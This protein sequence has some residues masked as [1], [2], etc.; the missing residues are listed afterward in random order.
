MGSPGTMRGPQG[1]TFASFPIPEYEGVYGYP[2]RWTRR[3][4]RLSQNRRAGVGVLQAEDGEPVSAGWGRVV[5]I[6]IKDPMRP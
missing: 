2:I 1:L 6:G 3:R 5:G 4:S